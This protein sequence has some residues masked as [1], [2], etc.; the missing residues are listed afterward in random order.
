MF[1]HPRFD[2]SITFMNFLKVNIIQIHTSYAIVWVL[3]KQ[4]KV[5]V[6][7]TQ[8]HKEFQVVQQCDY[9]F[10]IIPKLI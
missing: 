7:T 8:L 4:A 10:S 3:R 2:N 9:T 6:K 5:I 1:K